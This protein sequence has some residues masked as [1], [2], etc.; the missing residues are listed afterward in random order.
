LARGEKP[1]RLPVFDMDANPT[2]QLMGDTLVDPAA[3]LKFDN[4]HNT[5][6]FIFVLMILKLF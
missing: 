5:R 4:F 1:V 2:H 6:R 3:L